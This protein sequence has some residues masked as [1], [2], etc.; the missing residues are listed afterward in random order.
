MPAGH[1][2][3]KWIK[4]GTKSKGKDQ[5]KGQSHHLEGTKSAPTRAT[6]AGGERVR[7][8]SGLASPGARRGGAGRGGRGQVCTRGAGAGQ[9]AVLSD[10]SSESLFSV[11]ECRRACSRGLRR[12]GGPSS[13]WMEG[14]SK[15]TRS[16]RRQR[17]AA[18]SGGRGGGRW[19]SGLAE[20]AC[21]RA[22][23]GLGGSAPAPG[24]RATEHPHPVPPGRFKEER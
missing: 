12:S 18:E 22:G 21:G 10:S 9:R 23:L 20:A 4:R 6:Q 15:W 13:T 14:M 16:A 11:T 1:V 17:E 19:G 8:N 5:T 2:G 3:S 7:H 24:A